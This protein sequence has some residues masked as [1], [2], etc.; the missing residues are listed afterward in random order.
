MWAWNYEK[1]A[2]NV[3]IKKYAAA[4]TVVN[5]NV[6]VEDTQDWVDEEESNLKQSNF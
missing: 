1:E 5:E 2:V 4:L 3:P 6:E